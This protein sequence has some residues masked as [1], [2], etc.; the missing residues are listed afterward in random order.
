MESPLLA[1][2]F[3]LRFLFCV[4]FFRCLLGGAWRCFRPRS[5]AKKS[6]R[7]A[8]TDESLR[9][10]MLVSAVDA[11]RPRAG[12]ERERERETRRLLR[13]CFQKEKKILRGLLRARVSASP[14]PAP[15]LAVVPAPH[16]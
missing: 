5:V 16:I 9:L 15:D 4:F 3:A 6:T 2:N 10:H 13:S 8:F 14:L 1:G 12:S 11:L 7:R